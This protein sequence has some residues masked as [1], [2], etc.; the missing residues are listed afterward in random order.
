MAVDTPYGRYAVSYGMDNRD[1]PEQGVTQASG[2]VPQPNG[3]GSGIVYEDPDPATS[4]HGGCS[5]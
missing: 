5:Y 2:V 1:D 3:T 4:G